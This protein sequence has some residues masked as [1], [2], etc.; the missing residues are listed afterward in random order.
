MLKIRKDVKDGVPYGTPEGPPL[1]G[2]RFNISFVFYPY[3]AP[4]GAGL[5]PLGQS[6]ART[7]APQRINTVCTFHN[8]IACQ[9]LA[10]TSGGSGLSRSAGKNYRWSE[11]E[12]ENVFERSEL[13]SL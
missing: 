1:W 2:A 13:F 9:S 6:Q 7:H 12:R 5:A 8:G 3:Q 11:R 10:R 4:P